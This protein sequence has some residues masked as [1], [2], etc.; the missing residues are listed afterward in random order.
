ME[1]VA[2]LKRIWN[3]VPGIHFVQKI[4]ENYCPFL[5]LLVAQVGDLMSCGSKDILKN[6]PCPMY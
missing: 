1:Q 3:L 4:P 2:K 6:A 5:N